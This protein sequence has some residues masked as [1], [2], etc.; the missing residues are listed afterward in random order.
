MV[1]FVSEL[2]QPAINLS[3]KP[4]NELLKGYIQFIQLE[5]AL[6]QTKDVEVISYDFMNSI[7][8]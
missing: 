7:V 5:V 8:S 2:R 3:K 6:W 4:L 1:S